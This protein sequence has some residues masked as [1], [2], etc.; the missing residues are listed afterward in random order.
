VAGHRQSAS[1]S[2]D[3]GDG[4][5]RVHPNVVAGELVGD[6]GREF[7][8]DGGQTLESYRDAAALQKDMAMVR[9]AV[10]KCGEFT[11][12]EEDS[13]AKVKIANASFPKL[14][15]DTAAFKPEA[16]RVGNVVSTITSSACR[17]STLVRSSRSPARPST[18]SRRSPAD[19]EPLLP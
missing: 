16:V 6:E 2:V 10:E 14:G 12:K 13:E 5:T 11:V 18:S 17:T 1:I 7:G 15:D 9:E 4:G 3:A 8:V 19:V